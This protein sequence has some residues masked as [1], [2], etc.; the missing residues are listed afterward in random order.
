[1]SQIKRKAICTGFIQ[2]YSVLYKDSACRRKDRK[3]GR[4]EEAR[5]REIKWGRHAVHASPAF[6]E[7]APGA[8]PGISP[9]CLS[10]SYS[11]ALEVVLR[12]LEL[13]NHR[14]RVV[15]DGDEAVALLVKEHVVLPDAVL[16]GAL[17][18]LQVAEVAGGERNTQSI[19]FTLVR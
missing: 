15:L 12:L 13:I 9:R 5:R 17:A 1:M 8:V 19:S 3:S 4:K 16:S 2:P 10:V 6:Q 7:T 11:E 14:D 18:L